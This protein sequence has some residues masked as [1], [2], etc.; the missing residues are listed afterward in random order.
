MQKLANVS[1]HI[2]ME[3]EDHY[4]EVYCVECSVYLH[5]SCSWNLNLIYYTLVIFHWA[6]ILSHYVQMLSY[7]YMRFEIVMVVNRIKS[8]GMW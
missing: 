7:H 3:N 1:R 2:L 6:C 8:C 4:G 5:L